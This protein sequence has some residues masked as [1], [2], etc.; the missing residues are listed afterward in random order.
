MVETSSHPEI[1]DTQADYLPI[2]QS[3]TLFAG[4]KLSQLKAIVQDGWFREFEAEE[5]LVSPDRDRRPDIWGKV[6]VLLK[7]TVLVISNRPIGK[8]VYIG[9]RGKNA[10]IGE[11]EAISDGGPLG[12]SIAETQ[13][14]SF[15]M[16]SKDFIKWL[17]RS[18]RLARNLLNCMADKMRDTI[19]HMESMLSL[20]AIGKIA[21]DIMLHPEIKGKTSSF[22]VL[23]IPHPNQNRWAT[24][25]AIDPAVLSRTLADWSEQGIIVKAGNCLRICNKNRLLSFRDKSTTDK[26]RTT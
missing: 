8:T 10:V 21:D 14:M 4:I 26:N 18:P 6:H 17:D 19:H 1:D 11:L 20:T 7:G 13:V 12:S 22:E 3:H 25:L 5:T 24:Y 15:M 2:L 16:E 23:S 9:R